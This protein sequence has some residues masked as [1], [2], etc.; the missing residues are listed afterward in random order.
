[1]NTQIRQNRRETDRQESSVRELEVH[2][3]GC[4]HVH[5]QCAVAEI[6]R[7]Q[8]IIIRQDAMIKL[9]STS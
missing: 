9:L 4:W 5:Q 1:M 2:T 3:P 7:L 6:E 8:K